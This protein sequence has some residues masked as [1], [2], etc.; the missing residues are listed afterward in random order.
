MLRRLQP[1]P[2]ATNIRSHVL[3]LLL[4]VQLLVAYLVEIYTSAVEYF[5]PHG[6]LGRIRDREHIGNR[7]DEDA[8]P[9]TARGPCVN[10]IGEINA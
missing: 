6:R 9:S 8:P 5:V 4:K 1:R 7:L 2:Y 10:A 3:L